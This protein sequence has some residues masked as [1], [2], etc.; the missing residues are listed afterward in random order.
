MVNEA[1]GFPHL[2]EVLERFGNEVINAYRGKLTELDINTSEK[3]LFNSIELQPIKTDR[4]HIEV[5][6]SLNW[7]W[8]LIEEGL[9]GDKNGTSPYKAPNWKGSFPHLMEWIR[10][11]PIHIEA[12][13]T[14]NGKLPTTRTLDNDS[15]VRSA[16]VAMAKALEVNGTVAKPILSQSVRETF[17][18]FKAEIRKA[19]SMDMSSMVYSI[20]GD[21]NTYTI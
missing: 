21:A 5:S 12:S 9:R 14:Y 15:A 17:D 6:I 18:N 20:F 2:T 11:K 16:A 1:L 19:V 8:K 13:R 3:N 4:G 10:I 7:Y